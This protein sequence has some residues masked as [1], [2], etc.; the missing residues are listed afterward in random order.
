MVNRRE[1]IESIILAYTAGDFTIDEANEK[2][3]DLGCTF[4]LTEDKGAGSNA[5]MNVG[6]G[7][8]E[9]ITIKDGKVVGGAHHSYYIYYK[10]EIYHCDP[11]DE[12]TI[13]LGPPTED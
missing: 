9:P 8:P 10:G 4:N 5:I 2:L 12:E 3:K 7:S 13:V 1:E 11:A 6:I